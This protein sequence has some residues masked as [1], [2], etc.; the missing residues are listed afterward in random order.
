LLEDDGPVVI[1]SLSSLM[2]KEK[3]EKMEKMENEM[4]S[5]SL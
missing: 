5:L 4:K 3:K 1:A 2:E